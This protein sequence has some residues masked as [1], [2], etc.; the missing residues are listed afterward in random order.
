MAAEEK[1]NANKIFKMQEVKFWYVLATDIVERS[2][3][4]TTVE[5]VQ[6]K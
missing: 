3:L 4:K 1:N 6:N 2:A 5:E